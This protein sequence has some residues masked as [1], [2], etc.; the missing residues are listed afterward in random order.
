MFDKIREESIGDLMVAPSLKII[1]IEIGTGSLV[2][3]MKK[4]QC[5]EIGENPGEDLT[6]VRTSEKLT[7][8]K[9]HCLEVEIEKQKFDITSEFVEGFKTAQQAETLFPDAYF[10]LMPQIVSNKISRTRHS[11]I[12]M[13]ARF[14]SMLDALTKS[15]KGALLLS[16][17]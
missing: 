11:S 2:A 5:V 17:D 15:I 4:R 12:F 13:V 16:V 7:K 9:V 14:S 10:S 6:L 8:D 3:T 1:V